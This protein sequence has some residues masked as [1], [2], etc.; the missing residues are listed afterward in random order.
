MR[1]KSLVRFVALL[2]VLALALPV[3]AKPVS[4]TINIAQNAKF[5][6]SQVTAGEYRLLIDGD[7][8]TL[9]QNGKTMAEVTGRWE[10]RNEKSRYNSVLIG[11]NGEV[12]EVRFAG[13][14]RVL[15]ISAQ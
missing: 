14:N 11:S 8:V 7:K 6:S 1:S 10:Q 9:Q 5:G 2:A 15:V 3:L 12:Q 13:D 4:K